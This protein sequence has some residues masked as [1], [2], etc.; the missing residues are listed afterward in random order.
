MSH[1]NKLAA[2][3]IHIPFKFQWPVL[4]ILRH[5]K[6]Y[7][8]RRAR[9]T[10]NKSTKEH[11]IHYSCRTSGKI[12]AKKELPQTEINRIFKDLYGEGYYV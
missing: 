9:I 6:K 10:I 7:V 3:R 8:D 1:K 12:F 2:S 5:V 11:T 4:V